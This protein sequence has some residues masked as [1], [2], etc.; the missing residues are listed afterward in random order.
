M[1]LCGYMYI[2][3]PLSTNIAPSVF[4]NG[5]VVVYRVDSEQCDCFCHAMCR[6][7]ASQCMQHMI[8]LT[9]AAFATSTRQKEDYCVG[10][11]PLLCV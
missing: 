3:G 11:L 6:I 10:T 8:K 7:G 9:E 2:G 5:V 1:R 4:A